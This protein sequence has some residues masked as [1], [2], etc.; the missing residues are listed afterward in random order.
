MPGNTK[1]P[2]FTALLIL[3]GCLGDLNAEANQMFPIRQMDEFFYSL[4]GSAPRSPPPRPHSL[5]QENAL[6]THEPGY[7]PADP[8]NF[9]SP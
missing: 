5:G 8:P 9:L 3:T 2:A 7:A 1:F 6:G 4:K